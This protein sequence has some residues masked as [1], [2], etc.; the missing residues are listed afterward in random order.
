MLPNDIDT[1]IDLFGGGLN[2]GVNVKANKIIYNDIEFA[3]VDLLK[4]FSKN[5]SF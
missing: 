2:V 5:T 1:F 4:E 3:I